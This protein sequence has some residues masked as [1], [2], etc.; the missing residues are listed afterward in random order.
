QGLYRVVAAAPRPKPIGSG[1][2]PG[3]PLGLQCLP[4]PGLMAPVQDHW[5]AERTHSGVVTG[6]R[7]VHPADRLGLPRVSGSVHLHRH[8]RPAPPPA[9]RDTRP[10]PPPP[11][12]PRARVRVGRPP[13]RRRA[14][15]PGP[16]PFFCGFPR[17]PH[18]PPSPP[19]KT[20][21]PPP[22]V[23]VPLGL[24]SPPDPR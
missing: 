23:P 17:P 13:P 6:F 7:Y 9:R 3:L 1:L 24:A 19:R 11:A 20:P 16:P 8:L 12:P 21:P 4:D 15:A 22:A 2:K 10:P 5:Y 18:P 14:G